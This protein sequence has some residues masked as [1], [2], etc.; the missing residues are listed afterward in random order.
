MSYEG[1]HPAEVEAL[2]VASEGD[3]LDLPLNVPSCDFFCRSQGGLNI[4]CQYPVNRFPVQRWPP[5]SMH[6]HVCRIA[7]P[8]SESR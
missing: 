4:E 2:Q 6:L 7:R 1:C 8:L 5:A 3:N